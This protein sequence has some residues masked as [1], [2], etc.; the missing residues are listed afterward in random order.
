[1]L[2]CLLALVVIAGYAIDAAGV[3]VAPWAV[4]VIATIAVA[5][6]ALVSRHIDWRATGDL[7]PWIGVCVF[8]TLALLRIAWPALFPPGRGPDLT[9]HLLLVDYIEQHGHLVHDRSLDG[10]MGEMAHYTPGAHLLAVLIG[11]WVGSDGLRVFFPLLTGV[12]ALTAG[13]VFLICRRLLL[14]IPYS[15]IAVILLF[16]P[17]QYF[18]GAFTHDSFLAQMVATFFAVAA[19][20]AVIAW[21]EE[22]ATIVAA[23]IGVLLAAVFLSWPIWIGPL[24]LLFVP[25]AFT[26]DDPPKPHDLSAVALTNAEALAKSGRRRTT[27]LRHLAVGL[28]PL[29]LVSAIHVAG[30]WGWLVIVRTSG[31]VLEPG[32]ASIGW[33]LPLFA[34]AGALVGVGD[35]RA[36]I[37]VVLLLLISL[38]AFT[39]FV[40]A[41][42][43]GADTPYMAFKMVYFAIY[44]M[45]ALAAVAMGSP[46]RAWLARRREPGESKGPLGWMIAAL[47]MVLV[48]RPALTV[49]RA[50]PVVDLDLYAAGKWTRANVG[51]TCVDYLV[52]DAETAYWLHLAVLGNPRASDRMIEID[53]Y[54]PRAA[55]GPWI[56]SEGRTYAIADLRLLPDEVRSNVDVIAH[57]G[58]AAVIRR[59]DATIK[60]CD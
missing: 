56:T 17:A 57:Y 54:D 32:V 53:R 16:L 24:V 14:A 30:R 19:W 38:Q 48:V 34:I 26:V 59:K 28:A 36:R 45:A 41:R 4:L 51:Q 47:L 29:L 27:A 39:L 23:I 20:W 46:E 52:A 43:Q 5:A 13:F 49:P 10:S 18:Y 37:T 40:I 55:A 31:A 15:I 44:P 50:I 1:L 25:L 3:G 35:R 7:L 60:G 22:R 8:V 12:T 2:A 6:L 58:S 11:K 33:V 42:S 9:H 21:E